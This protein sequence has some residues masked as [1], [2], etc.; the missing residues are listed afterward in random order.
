M[1]PR[2]LAA[3]ATAVVIATI[4]AGMVALGSPQTARE[5]RFDQR[6]ID[7]LS[8]IAMAIEGHAAISG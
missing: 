5:R 8:E 2:L 1:S 4:G 7:D 3:F 6:R